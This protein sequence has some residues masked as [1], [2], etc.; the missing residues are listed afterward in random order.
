MTIP[1]SAL[2]FYEIFTSSLWY[3]LRGDLTP[4][5]VFDCE[6]NCREVVRVCRVSDRGCPGCGQL[7]LKISGH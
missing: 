1:Q 2:T 6:T 3:N 4:I 7:K 5:N